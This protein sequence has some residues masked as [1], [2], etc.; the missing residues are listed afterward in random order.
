MPLDQKLLLQ[1]LKERGATQPCHRCGGKELSVVN[2]YSQLSVRDEY[3]PSSLFIGGPSI[4]VVLV[5][6]AKCGAITAHALGALDMLPK[7]EEKS[8][9]KE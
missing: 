9:G 4:P 5:A 7:Q 3:S 2:K 1:R 8:D 6:C